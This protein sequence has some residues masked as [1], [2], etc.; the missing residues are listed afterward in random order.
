VAKQRRFAIFRRVAVFVYQ[1]ESGAG[2]AARHT[3]MR[4]PSADERG[5]A[6]AHL[7]VEGDFFAAGQCCEQGRDGGGQIGGGVGKEFDRIGH[8]TLKNGS[9]CVYKV[10]KTDVKSGNFINSE[11]SRRWF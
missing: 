8:R 10:L 2:G 11:K 3:Q 6:C 9:E 7:A 5:F 4:A 1:R